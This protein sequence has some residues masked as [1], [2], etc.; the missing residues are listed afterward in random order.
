MEQKIK[1]MTVYCGSWYG[2][3]PKY[4]EAAEILGHELAKNNIELVH[5]GGM[6]GMMGTVAK[7]VYDNGGKVMGIT[8]Q[9]IWDREHSKEFANEFTGEPMEL[10][11]VKPLFT[12]DLAERKRLL[13]EKGDVLCALPGSTGTL[14]ELYEVIVQQHVGIIKKPIIVLNLDGYYDLTYKQIELAA[15]EGFTSEKILKAFVMVDKPEDIIPAAK[16]IIE[17]Y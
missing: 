10:S 9:K 13:C 7:S 3:K 12:D 16:K 5:G 15:K 6:F 17:S 14:D 2:N 8:T 11:N 1:S 4:K